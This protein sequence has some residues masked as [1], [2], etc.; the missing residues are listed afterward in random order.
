[1]PSI[2][3]RKGFG[4]IIQVW[5]LYLRVTAATLDLLQEA[6]EFTLGQTTMT[7]VFYYVVPLLGL[8]GG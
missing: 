7:N 5:S 3:F 1:M 2:L 8:K 4:S 6:E